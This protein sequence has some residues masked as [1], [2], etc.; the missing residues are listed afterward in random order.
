M[1]IPI[2]AMVLLTIVIWILMYYRR[3]TEIRTSRINPQRLATSSTSV[4]VLKNV[5]ASD[6]LKNLLEMPVLFYMI[7]IIVE[8]NGLTSNLFLTLA[9]CY[10][11][12]RYIHSIIHVTYNRVMHRFYIYISSCLVLFSI[13]LLFILDVL[14]S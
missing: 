13:W 9:W 6:N 14:T 5:S 8:I 1:Y 11:V 4:D 10:V 12:L 3:I 7:C 2:T